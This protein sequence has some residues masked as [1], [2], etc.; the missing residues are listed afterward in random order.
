MNKVRAIN[1]AAMHPECLWDDVLG[2]I[3]EVDNMSATKALN[4][5]TPFE[6]LF[7]S[8]P[9]VNDLHILECFSVM[10]KTSLGYRILDLCTGK[11]IER[12]DVVLYEDLAADPNYLQNL[13]DKTYCK[14]EIEL[15]DHID[16]VSLPVS[17]VHMPIVPQ[18]ESSD[19]GEQNLASC[20][21]EMEV[22]SEDEIQIDEEGIPQ[23]DNDSSSDSSDDDSD[24]DFSGSEPEAMEDDVNYV[25]ESYMDNTQDTTSAE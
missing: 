15:P 9:Q 17:H 5:I 18:D 21:D 2:Y 25:T 6:K 12:R 14:A 24:S 20:A 19:D 16:F 10:Q 4:G 23:S 1:E 8:K 3:V 11:L 22:D 13:I 7:G